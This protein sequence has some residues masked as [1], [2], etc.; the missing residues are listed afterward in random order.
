MQLASS[1]PDTDCGFR[2]PRRKSSLTGKLGRGV[3][4]SVP[5][6]QMSYD[7][8]H[9]LFKPCVCLCVCERKKEAGGAIITPTEDDL[10][11]A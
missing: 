8:G 7:H 2:Q 5:A 3:G 4:E 10:N 6:V 9:T 1:E 11:S